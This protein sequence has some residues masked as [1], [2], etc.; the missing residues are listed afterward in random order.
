MPLGGRA[1]GGWRRWRNLVVVFLFV[2]MWHDVNLKL[3]IW[4]LFFPLAF[5]PELAAEAAARRY[6]P[7]RWRHWAYRHAAAAGGAANILLLVAVNLVGFGVDAAGGA[8][9]AAAV[10][11]TADGLRALGLAALTMFVGVQLDLEI[12]ASRG[13]AALV[14]GGEGGRRERGVSMAAGAVQSM[15]HV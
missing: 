12:E 6:G 5:A 3:L 11:T 7:H 4:G 10:L 13:D 2:A 1:D 14:E 15:K 8:A 9:A